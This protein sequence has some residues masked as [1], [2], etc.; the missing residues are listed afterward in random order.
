MPAIVGF[1]KATDLAIVNLKEN[2]R[3][4]A[5]R[6]R[7][8]K[9]LSNKISNIRINGHPDKRI[10]N[11]LSIGFDGLAAESL[12]ANM[13]IQGIYA[14]AGSACTSGAPEASRVLEAMG[15]E[16]GYAKGS[17]R[18]SLGMGTT[19]SDISY[20]IKTIPALVKHL[21]SMHR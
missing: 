19:D 8:Y 10:S 13:D 7:L 20:C 17:V 5:L 12:L 18:F 6:D 11:T 9:G 1:A 15:V 4:E 21:R 3:V 16:S 2:K 14:S